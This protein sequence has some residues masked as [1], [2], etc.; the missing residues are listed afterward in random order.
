MRRLWTGEEVTHAGRYFRLTA[1][2]MGFPPVQRPHP[3]IVMASQSPAAAARAGRLADGIFF[4]PQITWDDARRLIGV[5]REARAAAGKTGPGIIGASRSV[6]LGKDRETAITAARAYME[7]TFAMYSG[8]SMQEK[9]MVGL[10]LTAATVDGWAI[11]GSA[12]DCVAT[13]QRAEQ[14]VGLT[15]VSFSAYTLPPEPEARVEFVRRLG[16]EIVRP[17]GTT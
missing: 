8:W 3:P 1:G 16:E 4:G 12:A 11:V 14:E 13:L 15:H 5:Y 17:V 2:R 6:M 9:G 10:Q 7:R